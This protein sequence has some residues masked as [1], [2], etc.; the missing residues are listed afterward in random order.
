MGNISRRVRL[1]TAGGNNETMANGGL[2]LTASDSLQWTDE[3]TGTKNALYSIAFGNSGFVVAGNNGDHTYLARR[4]D[5]DNA[6]SR[7]HAHAEQRHFF[8]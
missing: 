6:F 2:L 3:T 4:R 8:R 5:L 1:K 7:D